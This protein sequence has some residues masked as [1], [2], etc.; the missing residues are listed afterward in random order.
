M[1]KSN[2]DSFLETLTEKLLVYSLGRGIEYYDMPAIR[3][4]L[5]DAKQYDYR[6][7]SLIMS[8]VTSDPFQMR[9]AE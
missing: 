4:I 7:S 6:W 8:L 9:K 5:R 1:L 2:R 3:R